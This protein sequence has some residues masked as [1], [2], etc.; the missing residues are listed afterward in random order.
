[1]SYKPIPRWK[2][3]VGGLLLVIFGG[4]FWIWGWYT[5]LN[6][7]YYYIKASMFFPAIFVVGLGIIVFPGYKEERIARGEDIS[8]LT[9]F[10]LLTPRWR[11]ILIGAL[12]MGI[13]NY[14]MLS[15]L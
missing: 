13:A 11:A 12:I 2:Q 7:G 8:G 9:G 3:K 14:L 15:S 1:M 10:R 4:G 6:E 5:A